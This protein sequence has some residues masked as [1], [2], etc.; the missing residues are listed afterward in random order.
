M[1]CVIDHLSVDHRVRVLQDFRDARG[2]THRAGEVA[3][4]RRLDFDWSTQDIVI[5]WVRD[6]RKETLVF[7]LKS[8]TGPG[9][10]RMR[11]YFAVEE[12]VESP[13]DIARRE[14]KRRAP[15][16]PALDEE[17]VTDPSQLDAAVKRIWALAARR[18]F[19]EADQQISLILR[20]PDPFGGRLESL[21]G[22]LVQLARAHA[23][24][25]DGTIYA[26]MRE[27]A[28][29]LW[30][31]WGSQATSGG[32]GEVRAVSIRAAEEVLAECDARRA[33][34]R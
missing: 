34:G 9:N 14:A 19:E 23:G 7:A 24:E 17:P 28:L 26:W 22:D 10:G 31:A 5:E 33:S 11:E 8:K 12:A 2:A 21:A 6:E 20:G 15:A 16:P 27:S 18:R 4:I 25:A 3:V 32:E 1:S 30:Y 29:S 13:E